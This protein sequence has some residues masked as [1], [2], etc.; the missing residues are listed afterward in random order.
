MHPDERRQIVG[1]VFQAARTTWYRT[2]NVN[3]TVAAAK[4]EAERHLRWPESSRLAEWVC[5]E[6]T[7]TF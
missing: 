4:D 6:V 3:R 2:G 1:L 5:R 7:K